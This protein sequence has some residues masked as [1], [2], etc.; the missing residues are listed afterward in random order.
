M[1][2]ATLFKTLKRKTV[3][4]GFYSEEELKTVSQQLTLNQ[5]ATA[6]KRRKEEDRSKEMESRESKKFKKTDKQTR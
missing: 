4:D 2:Q 6:T 3:L 1:N 5:K